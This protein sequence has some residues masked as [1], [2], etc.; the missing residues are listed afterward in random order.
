MITLLSPAK[1]LS[2]QAER[3]AT[4]PATTARLREDTAHLATLTRA[5]SQADIAQLMNLSEPLAELTHERFQA[6]ATTETTDNAQ[7]AIL[8]FAGDVYVGLD[9]ASLS[10]EELTFAQDRL[11]IL[12]G[13][14]GLLRPLDLIQPYR[15]E[16]GTRLANPAGKT[17]YDFWRPRLAPLLRQQLDQLGTDIIVNLASDEYAKAIDFKSLGARV[18]EVTFKEQTED[19]KL[20]TMFPYAKPARGMMAR[21][22]V[23]ERLS[24]PDQLT[25]FTSGG[26]R[27]REELSQGDHLVFSRPKPPPK[28][29]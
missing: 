9:A 1:K 23:R 10:H 15:L 7:Q 8:T 4:L 14:Y 24:Q 22:I 20:K 17:L 2:F 26:Y 29:G 21:H 27:Y 11:I 5:L 25:G 6:F 16:M 28:T 19:G 12:S 3:A 18:I 13:L